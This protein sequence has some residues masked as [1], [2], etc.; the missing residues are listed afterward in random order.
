MILQG[1]DIG[2]VTG[3]QVLCQTG[4]SDK[5]MSFPPFI[6]THFCRGKIYNF[7][8]PRVNFPVFAPEQTPDRLSLFLYQNIK[9]P[10]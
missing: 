2:R 10:K 7:V 1:N 9:W 4:Q 8:V 3:F 6:L 5:K